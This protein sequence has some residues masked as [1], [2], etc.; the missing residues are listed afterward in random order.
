MLF[1][2]STYKTS[3]RTHK[4][5]LVKLRSS[6]FEREKKNEFSSQN[7]TICP[8]CKWISVWTNKN[9]S[10]TWR[11]KRTWGKRGWHAKKIGEWMTN[12]NRKH[13]KSKCVCMYCIWRAHMAA[14]SKMYRGFAASF[15]LRAVCYLIENHPENQR[16]LHVLVMCL[17]LRATA[18]KYHALHRECDMLRIWLDI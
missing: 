14:Y 6:S 15:Y 2:W 18:T 13:L 11:G 9:H 1:N 4:R 8:H 3:I 7:G 12:N 16:V 10:N 5:M 17:H